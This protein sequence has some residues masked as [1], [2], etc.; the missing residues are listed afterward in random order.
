MRTSGWPW[1]PARIN[2]EA[3]EDVS[4]AAAL[5]R[6]TRPASDPF[7]HRHTET[8]RKLVTTS[9]DG[10]VN[11]LYCPDQLATRTILAS[12]Q[13]DGSMRPQLLELLVPERRAG[14]QC[15]AR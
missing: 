15:A 1:P 2:R 9:W 7:P 8:F 10:T 14:G 13:L 3:M 6:L 11:T 5:Q 4:A 12:E